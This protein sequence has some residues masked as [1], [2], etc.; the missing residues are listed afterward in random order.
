MNPILLRA[1]FTGAFLIAVLLGSY[2]F[3]R[4]VKTGEIAEEKYQDAIAYADLVREKIG[5]AD[6][7]AADN[8]AVRAEKAPR[9]KLITKEITRYVEVTPPA[10][11]CTLPGT[12]R[13]RHDAAATGLPTAAAEAGP[14]AAGTDAPVEDAAAIE[15]VAENYAIA[16]ECADKLAGWKTRYRRLEQ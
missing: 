1:L 5:I 11:R 13:V 15:T 4:H 3:G 8:A 9:E 16:R 2:W 6:E 12:W 14:M 10:Q 7:L